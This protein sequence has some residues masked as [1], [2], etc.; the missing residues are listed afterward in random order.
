MGSRIG[1]GLSLFNVI[2][3]SAFLWWL[4]DQPSLTP[5]D[6][7]FNFQDKLYHAVAYAGYGTLLVMFVLNWFSHWSVRMQVM[8]VLAIGLL[9]AASDEYH[10]TFVDGRVGSVADWIADAIGV[11]LASLLLLRRRRA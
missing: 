8:T 11:G 7:G 5:P 2:L 3:A 10:Q 4:S 1:R 6:L 9:F